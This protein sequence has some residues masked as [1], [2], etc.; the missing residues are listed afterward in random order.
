MLIVDDFNQLMWIFPLHQKVEALASFIAWMILT[1]KQSG[2]EVKT[3]RTDK[4]GEFTSGEMGHFCRDRGI[5]REFANTGTPF[6]NGVVER[7]YRTI[8]EMAR[9]MLAHKDL[10]LTLWAEHCV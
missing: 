10:R 1:K 6:K 9:T 2:K 8:V 7:K 3:V 5:Q 4:G